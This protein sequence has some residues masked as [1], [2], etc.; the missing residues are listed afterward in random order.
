MSMTKEEYVKII[1][2]SAI[3]LR[4]FLWLICTCKLIRLNK[5]WATIAALFFINSWGDITKEMDRMH[6]E[7][8]KHFEK[9][10]PTNN[11]TIKFGFCANK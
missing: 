4:W 6:K 9:D 8:I 10:E 11:N 1:D 5:F 3:I 2:S 7:N